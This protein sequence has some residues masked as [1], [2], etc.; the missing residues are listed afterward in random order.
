M[1]KRKYSEADFC[2]EFGRWVKHA[3]LSSSMALEMKVSETDSIP[4]SALEEHQADALLA[5]KHKQLYFK[6]PDTSFS[7]LPCDSFLLVNAPGMV[8]VMFRS[9]DH[10]Q[11]EFFMI[12][13]DAWKYE[14]LSS[15]RK[16]LTEDR[17]REI[18]YPQMFA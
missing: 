11:K 3:K 4:F 14:E 18:S 8:V 6:I 13:I 5:A 2:T 9:Q 15:E 1:K 16:S 7:P 17:A 12:P 10:G